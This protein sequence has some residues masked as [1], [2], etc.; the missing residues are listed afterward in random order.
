MSPDYI[1][2]N[3]FISRVLSAGGDIGEIQVA[4]GRPSPAPLG[5]STLSLQGTGLSKRVL[6]L[7]PNTLAA[8]FSWILRV[9]AGSMELKEL[10]AL[11]AGRLRHQ[12]R[13]GVLLK[14]GSAIP[15]E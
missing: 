1:C 10:R 14:V 11:N 9:S 5:M 4:G 3:T 13:V 8:R 12:G 2:F 6:F 15:G 7:D